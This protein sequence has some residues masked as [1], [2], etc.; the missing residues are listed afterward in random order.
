MQ[1]NLRLGSLTGGSYQKLQLEDMEKVLL[2]DV[3][4]PFA[5]TLLK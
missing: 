2:G 4:D 3:T 1:L 5:V